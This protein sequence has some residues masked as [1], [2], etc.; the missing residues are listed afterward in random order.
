MQFPKRSPLLKNISDDAFGEFFNSKENMNL[1]LKLTNIAFDHLVNFWGILSKI[2]N[3]SPIVFRIRITNKCNLH[4]HYCYVGESLNKKLDYLLTLEEWKKVIKRVPRNTL[5]DITGGEPLLAPNIEEIVNEM[6]DRKLKVSLITNGTIS[7]ESLLKNMV[8]KKLFHFMVSFDGESATH[9]K[10]RGEGSFDRA[11][12]TAKKV[13]EYK[14]SQNT[15]YP[16]VVAKITFTENN[17]QEI[18]SLCSHL[19]TQIGFDGI[20]INL[21][22]ANK[23]RNSLVN[24]SSLKD[25][26]FWSGNTIT[27]SPDKALAMADAA[28]GL[29]LKFAGKIQIRPEINLD[30]IEEYFKN[31]SSFSPKNCYKYR[32]IITMYS[33]GLLSPCDLG[34]NVGNIREIDY[35]LSRTIRQNSMKEFLKQFGNEK[36]MIPGCQG[37]C[38][39]KHEMTP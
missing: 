20:T 10:V 7:K 2:F 8:D 29:F 15:R 38:L 3:L 28:K 37:C 25:S 27:F 16:F 6:L 4:C 26:K 39:K 23:A 34:L 14:R 9:D 17:Y 35:N 31:P 21:L 12:N 13:I 24:E 22:F 1:S 19:F 18:E 36:K 30:Q 33:N 11:I 32:S 5:I